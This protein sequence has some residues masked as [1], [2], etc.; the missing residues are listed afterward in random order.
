MPFEV[1]GTRFEMRQR[2]VKSLRSHQS[3]TDPVLAAH[4][5]TE[6]K[7][8]HQ[9]RSGPEELS[10]VIVATAHNRQVR[11]LFRSV[12]LPYR[13]GHQEQVSTVPAKD[14]FFRGIGA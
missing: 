2:I 11:R 4:C 10:T 7:R 12:R 1:F 5:V 6:Y 3:H 14:V 13:T 8:Q 9:M